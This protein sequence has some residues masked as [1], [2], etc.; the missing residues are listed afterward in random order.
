LILY[1]DGNKESEAEAPVNQVPDTATPLRLGALFTG[2]IDE[3]AMYNRALTENEVKKDMTGISLAVAS[4]GKLPIAW[5][6]I[7][8]K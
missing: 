2:S 5:G 3:F 1:V 7:K 8:N 4:Q 6:S